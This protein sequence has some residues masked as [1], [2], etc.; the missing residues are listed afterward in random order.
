[1]DHRRRKCVRLTR[2]EDRP[3]GLHPDLVYDSALLAGV[4]DEGAR[5]IGRFCKSWIVRVWG[6]G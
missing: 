2:T 4:N 5:N 3:S 1:M 6:N